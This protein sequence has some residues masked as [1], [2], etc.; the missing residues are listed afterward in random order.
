MNGGGV[1]VV[2]AL[3]VTEVVGF[4]VAD[5]ATGA[6][7]VEQAAKHAGTTATASVRR[8]L[9]IPPS[10][11]SGQ[12]RRRPTSGPLRAWRLQCGA[13]FQYVC[14]STGEVQI[15]HVLADGQLQLADGSRH[16]TPGAAIK[17]A[18]KE[19]IADGWRTWRRT[20]DNR[21]LAELRD[22]HLVQA[23]NPF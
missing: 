23:K 10:L 9:P 16:H 7:G 4:A 11:A 8:N 15:A 2:G 13:L 20:T 3:V 19:R 14:R 18:C 6:A 1:V 21:T 12:A 22:G 17:L 5:G